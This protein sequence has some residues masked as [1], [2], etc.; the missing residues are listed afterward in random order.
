MKMTFHLHELT[1]NI[2]NSR[3]E[4]AVNKHVVH[5]QDVER[6]MPPFEGHS[7]TAFNTFILLLHY[8]KPVSYGVKF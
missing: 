6:K 1:E 2:L 3:V 8:F 4:P 7:F 5:G